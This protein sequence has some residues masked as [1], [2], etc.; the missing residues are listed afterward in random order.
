MPS[1][2][3]IITSKGPTVTF[4]SL[5]RGRCLYFGMKLPG[6]TGKIAKRKFMKSILF[7]SAL[8]IA[9]TSCKKECTCPTPT[10]KTITLQPGPDNGN[11]VTANFDE[12]RPASA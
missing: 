6:M 1:Q 4:N 10:Q 9:F 8:I 12:G 3:L 2:G 5:L 7:I 11:D